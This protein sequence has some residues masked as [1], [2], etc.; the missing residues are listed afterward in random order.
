MITQVQ[1]F[2]K[3]SNCKKYFQSIQ[4]KRYSICIRKI[5]LCQMFPFFPRYSYK[6]FRIEVKTNNSI[7]G[8]KQTS[9]LLKNLPSVLHYHGHNL[10]QLMVKFKL[11]VYMNAKILLQSFGYSDVHRYT[12]IYIYLDIQIYS[13][14]KKIIS[15]IE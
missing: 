4:D 14:T 15:I 1:L 6:V 5:L 9:F 13:N 3:N 7:G 2:M 10:H 8:L 12:D 11:R